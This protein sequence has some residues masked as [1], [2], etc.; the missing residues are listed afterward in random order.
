MAGALPEVGE[1]TADVAPAKHHDPHR[2]HFLPS[3]TFASSTKLRVVVARVR[4]MSSTSAIAVVSRS[5][6]R[7]PDIARPRS[8]LEAGPGSRRQR[9]T[10]LLHRAAR[11]QAAEVDGDEA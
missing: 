2:Q 5:R 4:D 9:T 7:G 3:T 11:D 1:T 6:H 10:E 8:L